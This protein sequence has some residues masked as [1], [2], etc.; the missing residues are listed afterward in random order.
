MGSLLFK[1]S[2]RFLNVP[3]ITSKKKTQQIENKQLCF[4]FR[5]SFLII[6][7]SPPAFGQAY[8]STTLHSV[9]GYTNFAP[10]PFQP[11]CV[12]RLKFFSAVAP[13]HSTTFLKNKKQLNN[14]LLFVFEL[15]CLLNCM[16]TKS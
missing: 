2:V 4:F 11:Y 10:T 13:S 15:F 12:C 3:Q 5:C 7:R 16:G 14:E 8:E 1:S 9:F 6:T